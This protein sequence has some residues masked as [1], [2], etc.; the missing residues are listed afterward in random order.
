M[1]I[2]VLS[3]G[4]KTFRKR[5]AAIRERG[6]QTS[7]AVDDAA[8]E[9]VGA[10]RKRGDLALVEFSNDIVGVNGPLASQRDTAR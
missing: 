10:V 2:R 6:A 8:R 5:F 3:T 4:E 9:I 1:T 7:A